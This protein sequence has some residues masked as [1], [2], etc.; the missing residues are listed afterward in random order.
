MGKY[1]SAEDASKMLPY[2]KTY[3]RDIKKYY[4]R[5]EVLVKR[6]RQLS[7]LTS[8]SGSRQQKIDRLRLKIRKKIELL[9]NRIARWETELKELFINICDVPTGRINVPV[10]LPWMEALVYFCIL[11]ETTSKDIEWHF[12]NESYEQAR[13]YFEKVL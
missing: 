6:S 3:C 12:D 10:Y 9:N 8:M 2:L 11:P 13:K 7:E 5:V 4:Q 1:Y